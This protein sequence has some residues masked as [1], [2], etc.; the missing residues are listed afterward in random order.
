MAD[1][2]ESQPTKLTLTPKA[3]PSRALRYQLLPELC[4]QKPGNA[5]EHYRRAYQLL[6]QNRDK[7]ADAA[8]S[9]W[10]D[11]PISDLP[12]EKVAAFL[13]PHAMMFG[14]LEA[15]AYCESCDWGY[16]DRMR[17]DGFLVKVDDIHD[18]TEMRRYLA[19]RI[20]LELAGSEVEKALRSV[21]VGFAMARHAAECPRVI[22]G[23]A[24][25]GG[26]AL[27]VNLLEEIVQHP[28]APNLYWALTDLPSPLIDLQ[29]ALQGE[30]LAAYGNFPGLAEAAANLKAGPMTEDQVKKCVERLLDARLYPGDVPY[31]NRKDL[32]KVVLH[33]HD[34][35]VKALI[36]QGRPRGNVEAMP[37][38]QV[39]L[40]HSLLEYEQVLDELVKWQG[41]PY[42]QIPDDARRD[43]GPLSQRMVDIQTKLLGRGEGCAAIPFAAMFTPSFA[44]VLNARTRVDRRLAALRCIEAIRLFAA[45]RDGKLPA[46]LEDIK[47]V[48][49]PIDPVSGKAFPYKRDGDKAVL[50]CEPFPGQDADDR[51][52]NPRYE[53]ILRR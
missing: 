15:A 33:G 16:T 27:M 31:S 50:C 43:D 46:K 37:H 24:G 52:Y 14:E 32:A 39:A 51:S 6:K 10:L 18:L 38:V 35:S 29:K 5:A 49:V 47:E 11:M 2:P 45:A 3:P 8:M 41:V 23:L 42:W 13:K 30:R 17:Q 9:E 36:K 44:K 40:L 20:R 7:I 19:L 1:E 21:R 4:D 28:K 26:A 22:P 34:I 25:I 53:L 12:R 48:P